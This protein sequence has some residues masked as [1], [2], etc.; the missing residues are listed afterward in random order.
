[1]IIEEILIK[2]KDITELSNF[3]TPAIAK[4]YYEINYRQD[5]DNLSN[6]YNF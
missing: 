2:N 4:Y 1:M 5:I 6:I 3:K